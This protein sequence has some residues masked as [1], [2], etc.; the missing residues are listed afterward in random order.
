MRITGDSCDVFVG[1][2]P[3]DSAPVG[4]WITDVRG[5]NPDTFDFSAPGVVSTL[6]SYPVLLPE[7]GIWLTYWFSSFCPNNPE[8]NSIIFDRLALQDVVPDTLVL[9]GPDFAP[10]EHRLTMYFR[11]C[12]EVGYNM[13]TWGEV[14]PEFHK[15][16]GSLTIFSASA[17]SL[18]LERTGQWDRFS[19]E[20]GIDQYPFMNWTFSGPAPF[21]KYSLPQLPPWFDEYYTN[22]SREDFYL[23]KVEIIQGEEGEMV[24]TERTYITR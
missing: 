15:L 8:R 22:L 21:R 10:Q 6:I 4:G 14:P 17:D 12:D 1:V 19:C 18:V 7:G 3:A 5:D 16:A 24:L 13:E 2:Y 20:W 23:E 9:Y 11:D